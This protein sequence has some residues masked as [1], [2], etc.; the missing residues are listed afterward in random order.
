MES[1]PRLRTLLLLADA[2][3]SEPVASRTPSRCAGH[4]H[5][6][7]LHS[8]AGAGRQRGDHDE[9]QSQ[10]TTR[11]WIVDRQG[12]SLSHVA[13]PRSSLQHRNHSSFLLPLSALPGLFSLSLSFFLLHVIGCDL[14]L[15]SAIDLQV[16]R[17][18]SREYAAAKASGSKDVHYTYSPRSRPALYAS[19]CNHWSFFSWQLL[20]RYACPLLVSSVHLAVV[21]LTFRWSRAHTR[22]MYAIDVKHIAQ[23]HTRR[24]TDGEHTTTGQANSSG[25]SHSSSGLPS[26]PKKRSPSS[27]KQCKRG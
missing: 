19:L 3:P 15:Y 8:A 20:Y 1:A 27:S 14:F 17:T 25:S 16:G 6:A 11:A 13:P 21:G 10:H 24:I 7:V 12:S 23:Q 5:S 4:R 26:K 18:L 2:P 22:A 9:G